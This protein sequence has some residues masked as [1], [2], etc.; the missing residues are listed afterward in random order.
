MAQLDLYVGYMAHQ[1][2]T[3]RTPGVDELFLTTQNRFYGLEV[4]VQLFLPHIALALSR[5]ESEAKTVSLKTVL[6]KT[7]QI[8]K[9]F[10]MLFKSVLKLCGL[11]PKIFSQIIT[12]QNSSDNNPRHKYVNLFSHTQKRTNGK[13]NRKAKAI[14]YVP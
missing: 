5:E 1:Q 6:L 7:T 2:E 4:I 12:L 9:K 11:L 10:L 8:T 13:L 3:L 14:Y